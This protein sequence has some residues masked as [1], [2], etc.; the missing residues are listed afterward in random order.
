MDDRQ[1]IRQA[2]GR[3]TW[4]LRRVRALAA[5]SRFLV[6]GLAGAAVACLGKGYLPA[7]PWVAGGIALG[8]GMIGVGYGLLLPVRPAHVARLA[9]TR[10]DLK[11]RLTAALEHLR[12]EETGD[13]ARAQVAE[14]A[15]RLRR[16]RLQDAFPIR[17]APEA[18]LAGPLL[19]LVIGVGLLPPIAVE[20]ASDTPPATRP[21][22]EPAE[23][24]EQPLEQQL[25][26][27]ETPKAIAPKTEQQDSP[28]GPRAPRTEA[29][30]EKAVFRDTKM[31]QQ[32]PDFG[33]FV[34]QGDDRLKML[35]RPENLPDLQRDFTQ[36]P[37]QVMIHRMQNQIKSGNMQGLSWDQIEKLLSDLGQGEQRGGNGATDDLLQE[38]QKDGKGSPDRMLSALSRALKRRGQDPG[39]QGSGKGKDLR[40]APSRQSGEGAG[41]GEGDGKNGGKEDGQPGG[42]Q[43]G[44]ERS[45][46]TRQ[47][48]TTRIGGD[49]QDTTLDGEGRAGRMEAYD[50][51]LSGKGEKAPSQLPYLSVFSRYK[52]MMEEALA[53]EP[54]P[55]SYREQV[56]QYFKTL[57]PR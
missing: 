14:T 52:K 54:I 22:G 56:K 18:R 8:L 34:K 47:D 5:G 10:L 33:S 27:A 28:I 29:G 30:D 13:L 6:L 43:P 1:Q 21:E 48:P 12:H 38:L 4:R 39:G 55:L 2:M 35:A 16:V 20:F 31:S 24:R 36:N 45:L 50:T 3:L 7:W 41:Q 51:N 37:Y 49:K 15:A 53:K 32:R 9:D 57:E 46:Q 25:A 26:K 44:T 40:E 17:F 11:E 19:A 23:N 42:S